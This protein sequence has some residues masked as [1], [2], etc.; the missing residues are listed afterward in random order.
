MPTAD[1]IISALN[2]EP[3]DEEGGF[4]RQ[5]WILPSSSGAP[6]G[7]AIMYLVTPHSFS[8]LH[9]L[10]ADE[11]FHFY[12]GDPCEQVVIDSDGE[13]TTHIL[14]SDVMAGQHVQT[15][16]PR[17]TW[18]GTRLLPGGAWALLGTTMTPGFHQDGFEL[19]TMGDL[20]SL[21]IEV[22]SIA[23]GYLADGA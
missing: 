18:Q 13:L 19:A 7:T 1:Q 5:T 9:R 4:F 15:V 23:A 2:L 20:A 17:N 3:L 21:P 6:R 14:G 11:V 22:A 8:A 10:D 12:L 16:V